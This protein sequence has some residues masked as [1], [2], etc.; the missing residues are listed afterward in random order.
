MLLM[1]R[2]EGRAMNHG[3]W[4]DSKELKRAREKILPQ[5]LKKGT[6]SSVSILF[7]AH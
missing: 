6:Y 2:T 4:V 3:M 5:S 7:L 1:L